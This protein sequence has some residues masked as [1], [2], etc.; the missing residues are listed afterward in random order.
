MAFEDM[1]QEQRLLLEQQMQRPQLGSPSELR[2]AMNSICRQCEMEEI[3]EAEAID[4]YDG[5]MDAGV[6]YQIAHEYFSTLCRT[7]TMAV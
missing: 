3:D 7:L 1:H 6:F 2:E 5:T 4:L